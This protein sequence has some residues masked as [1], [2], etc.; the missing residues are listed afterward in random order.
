MSTPTQPTAPEPTEAHQTL[1]I[2]IWGEVQ[3][4]NGYSAARLIAESEAAAVERLREE[5]RQ[6]AEAW[7]T[8]NHNLKAALADALDTLD[9][10]AHQHCSTRKAERDYRGQIAGSLVTDS[11]ALSAH[12][13]ALETLAEHGYFRVIG[14]LRRMVVGYWPE[15]DPEKPQPSAEAKP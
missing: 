14:S 12:A 9:D 7:V 2:E 11:S 13:S 6:E 10:M 5:M 15:N 4:D 1:A 3:Q 8:T